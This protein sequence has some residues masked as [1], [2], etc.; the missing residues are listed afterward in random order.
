MD[1]GIKKKMN[2]NGELRSNIIGFEVN[3]RKEGKEMIV[4]IE[5]MRKR[6]E[7]KKEGISK[8]REFKEEKLVKEE[9]N[10]KEIGKG[11][12]NKVIGI[13][14]NDIGEKIFKMVNINRIKGERSEERNEGG[15]EKKEERNGNIKMKRREIKRE[16]IE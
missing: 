14:K 3:M 9:K 4:K 11:E 13:E 15:S 5:K 2:L 7:M 1:I 6:N 12:K 16:K 8:D 10:G